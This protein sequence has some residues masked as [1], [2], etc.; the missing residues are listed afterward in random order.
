MV[1]TKLSKT[2]LDGHPKSESDFYIFGGAIFLLRFTPIIRTYFKA[3]F[4]GGERQ[5]GKI[6][7][8]VTSYN[9]RHIH[10]TPFKL[11]RLWSS[12]FQESL[13]SY[14]LYS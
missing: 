10:S 4:F 9:P 13:C 5:T 14:I 12:S 8:R 2:I 6:F 11:I 3:R 1:C 7:I